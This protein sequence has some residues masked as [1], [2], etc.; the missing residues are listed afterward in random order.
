ML[1]DDNAVS[2]FVDDL[3]VTLWVDDN[4][5]LLGGRQFTIHLV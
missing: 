5:L 3:A 4:G 2:V 1:A